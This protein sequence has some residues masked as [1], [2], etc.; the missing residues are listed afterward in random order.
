MKLHILYENEDWMPPLRS[1]LRHRGLTWAEHLMDGDRIEIGKLPEP[2][3]WLNRMSPSSH[4]RGHQGGLLV[5]REWIFQL[6]QRGDRVINGSAALRLELSK[7]HQY[8]ALEASGIRTPRT[9]G[10]VGREG[11]AAA[12]RQMAMPFITKHNQGGKGLG[13][14]LFESLGTFDAYV[15]GP[16]FEP[17]PDGITLLQQYIPPR[18]QTI[19]RAEIVNGKFLYAVK[20][21]TGQGFELCPADVCQVGDDFCPT[22][23]AGLFSLREDISAQDPLIARLAA[24]TRD[25]GLDV[26]GIEW[27]EDDDGTPYVYDI[28][29]TTNFNSDVETRHGLD[30]MGAIADLCRACLCEQV[31]GQEALKEAQ[32]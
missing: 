16:D 11:L 29:A 9:I 2:G 22:D 4:T 30:G 5:A 23:G 26:A 18:D 10:V 19:T 15:E 32:R 3:V 6:E 12:A 28:N 21:G 13:V 25:Q 17:S 27:V 1:A 31:A 8:A 24:F 7:L 14:R 20:V